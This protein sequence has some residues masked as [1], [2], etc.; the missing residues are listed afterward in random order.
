VVALTDRYSDAARADFFIWQ[1]DVQTYLREAARGSKLRSDAAIAAG[2]VP[3]TRLYLTNVGG[4]RLRSQG[5]V[6]EGI[7]MGQPLA[8]T[9]DP[10]IVSFPF[11]RMRGA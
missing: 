7:R 10:N 6:D 2:L 5:A 4:S 8:Y 9:Q 3:G 1:E 11:G